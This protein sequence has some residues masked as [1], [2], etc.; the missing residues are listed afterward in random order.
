MMYIELLGLIKIM[1]GKGTRAYYLSN[2]VFTEAKMI[3]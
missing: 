2:L 3:S 1:I